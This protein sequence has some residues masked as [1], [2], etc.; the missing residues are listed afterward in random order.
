MTSDTHAVFRPWGPLPLAAAVE[1]GS[2]IVTCSRKDSLVSV[3]PG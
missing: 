2:A 3:T 1:A